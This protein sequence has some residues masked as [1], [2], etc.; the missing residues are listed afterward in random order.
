MRKSFTVPAQ[1]FTDKFFWNACIWVK[2]GFSATYTWV[3]YVLKVSFSVKVSS[4][5]RVEHKLGYSPETHTATT[6]IGRILWAEVFTCSQ[7]LDFLN[8]EQS[9]WKTPLMASWLT[10]IRSAIVQM[11]TDCSC[12]CVR[13]FI[14]NV[15][16]DLFNV[17]MSFSSF[18]TP[19]IRTG[20]EWV[21]FTK[22]PR[23]SLRH[24]GVRHTPVQKT[25]LTQRCSAVS[26]C[27]LY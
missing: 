14:H 7:R 13:C 8:M 26:D 5:L 21:I 2:C 19:S 4:H 23:Q 24:F 9:S 3:L 20:G 11:Y 10:Y 6:T 1:T 16:N 18:S 25:F 22:V 12:T 27:T 15:R 17:W